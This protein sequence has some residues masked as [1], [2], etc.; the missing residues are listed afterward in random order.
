MQD[1]GNPDLAARIARIL[2][3]GNG[4]RLPEAVDALLDEDPISVAVTLLPID[5][6]SSGVCGVM[7]RRTAQQ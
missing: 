6:L 5:Q 1:V 7:P 3:L 2:P 4:R